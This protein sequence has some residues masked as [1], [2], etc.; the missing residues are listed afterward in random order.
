M[1]SGLKGRRVLVTGASKGIGLACAR[2]FAAEGA[3]VVGVSLSID[4]LHAARED[5][6]RA[7]FDMD[8]HAVD[9]RDSKAAAALI[10]SLEE[11]GAPLDVLVNSA[12]AARR[13]PLD[14]LGHEAFQGA[15]DAKYFTYLNVLAPLIKRMAARGHGS[16]VNIVGQGGKQANPI[17]I[18]GG[19]ANAALMLASVGYARAYADKGLRVNVI[20]PGMTRTDRVEEGISAAM[21]ASGRGREELLAEQVAEIPMGRMAEPDEVANV[22]VFLAGDL[23]S[24]V[25]GAVIPM[26]GA[27]T[28]VI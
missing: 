4:N 3:S 13:F 24:Y 11:S 26:D 6:R 18:A 5:L 15:L 7:G 10:A 8:I 21:R 22:A 27:K 2:A 20:N 12:G 28:S 19:G 16:I 23:A 25:T 1:E 14:E 17:H 9:L